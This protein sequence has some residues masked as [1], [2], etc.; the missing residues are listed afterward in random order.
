MFEAGLEE[1]VEVLKQK[2]QLL[3]E[4]YCDMMFLSDA[5]SSLG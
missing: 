1:S 4:T 2:V 5:A 3:R